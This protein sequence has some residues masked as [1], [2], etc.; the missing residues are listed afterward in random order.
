MPMVRPTLS[1]DLV[2]LEQDYI[3]GY[4]DG[5]RVFY[6]SVTDEQGQGGV[7]SA[8]EKMDW[9]PIW[10]SVNDEFNSYL[11][12]LPDLEHLVDAKFFICDGNHRRIA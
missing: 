11:K 5:A 12:S 8:A 10:N 3:H 7:F 9:D 2:K 1:C 4:K 6:I